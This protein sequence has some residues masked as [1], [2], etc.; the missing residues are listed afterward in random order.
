[1][2]GD[3]ATVAVVASRASVGGKVKAGEAAAPAAPKPLF[4]EAGVIG[5]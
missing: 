5:E 2:G 1:M 4:A 3:E